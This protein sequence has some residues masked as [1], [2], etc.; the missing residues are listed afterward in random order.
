MQG[1]YDR[2]ITSEPGCCENNDQQK[3]SRMPAYH[4]Y[5]VNNVVT[6][7]LGISEFKATCD[8]IPIIGIIY[9][10]GGRITKIFSVGRS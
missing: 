8:H 3:M 6:G 10:H 7:Y 2:G 9:T 1:I 5:T 4:E